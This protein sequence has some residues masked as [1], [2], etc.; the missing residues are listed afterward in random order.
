M[1]MRDTTALEP[2]IH[3]AALLAQRIALREP[4]FED[5]PWPAEASNDRLENFHRF[6]HALPPAVRDSYVEY[7]RLLVRD[8]FRQRF[9][10]SAFPGQLA[11]ARRSELEETAADV[12]GMLDLKA[13]RWLPFIRDLR[14]GPPGFKVA[15]A[16]R[17]TFAQRGYQPVRSGPA[18]GIKWHAPRGRLPDALLGVDRGT[19]RSFVSFFIGFPNSPLFFDV[20]EFFLVGQSFFEYP[21]RVISEGIVNGEPRRIITLPPPTETDA[22]AMTHRGI[23]LAEWLLPHLKQALPTDLRA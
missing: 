1:A 4:P 5:L 19:M 10:L 3:A 6:K 8:S 16:M 23:D 12:D 2:A 7:L 21:P 17:A 18:P 13:R 9:G 22:I 11:P 20:G 14:D 15:D